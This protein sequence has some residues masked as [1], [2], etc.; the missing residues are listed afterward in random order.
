MVEFVKA[1]LF[2]IAN[3]QKLVR[4]YVEDGVILDRS[5]DEVATNIRSYIL[6]KSQNEIIGYLALHIHSIRL[7]EIRSLI[8]SKEYRGEGVGFNLVKMALS[9][10]KELGV[11]EV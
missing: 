2:D 5:D 3:M 1:D 6:A 9:E 10:A 11:K 8:V 4:E 7:A